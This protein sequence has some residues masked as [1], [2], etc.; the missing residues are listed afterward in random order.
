M[1]PQCTWAQNM[2]VGLSS[3]VLPSESWEDGSAG[4][5]ATAGKLEAAPGVRR[6]RRT[7]IMTNPADGTQTTREIIYTDRDKAGSPCSQHCLVCQIQ[8]KY[9][10][11]QI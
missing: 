1:T 3:G 8:M 5:P 7:I 2:F 4:A 11:T 10:L 9:N 6:I